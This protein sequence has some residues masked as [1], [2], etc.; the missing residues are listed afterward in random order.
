M[1]LFVT[2]AVTWLPNT[3]TRAGHVKEYVNEPMKYAPP[4]TLLS[5]V[6]RATRYA[7]PKGIVGNTRNELRNEKGRGEE[8]LTIVSVE[9][10]YRLFLMTAPFLRRI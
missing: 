2:A 4:E 6:I 8:V 5:K 10:E 9:S 1:P 7:K 3:S